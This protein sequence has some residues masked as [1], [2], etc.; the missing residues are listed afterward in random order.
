[1]YLALK[2]A[3]RPDPLLVHATRDHDF[4]VRQNEKP[5]SSWTLLRVR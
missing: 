5:P 3:G 4:G 1:M 2:H